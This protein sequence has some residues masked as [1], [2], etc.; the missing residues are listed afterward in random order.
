[1]QVLMCS[2]PDQHPM[3]H[4]RISGGIRLQTSSNLPLYNKEPITEYEFQIPPTGTRGRNWWTSRQLVKIQRRVFEAGK[5]QRFPR[6]EC[7]EERNPLC[8]PVIAGANASGSLL[9][10]STK[11][12][13]ASEGRHPS[14]GR[15]TSSSSKGELPVS[16]AR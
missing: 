9:H 11:L 3:A 10:R 1:M 6:G 15:R 8:H 13:T 7:G 2:A 5:R 16:V 4:F 14:R 12:S